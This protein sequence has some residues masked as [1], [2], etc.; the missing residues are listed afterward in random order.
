MFLVS[1][2]VE[3]NILLKQNWTINVGSLF[4]NVTFLFLPV[5]HNVEVRVSPQMR[6]LF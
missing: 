1:F 4:K 5:T 2:F 6:A 3:A